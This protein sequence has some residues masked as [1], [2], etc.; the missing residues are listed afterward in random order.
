MKN[1]HY[2][3]LAFLMSFSSLK[4]AEEGLPADFLISSDGRVVGAHYG[5]HANDQ[6]SVPDLLELAR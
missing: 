6:W 1:L 3:I 5:R 4:G 2:L